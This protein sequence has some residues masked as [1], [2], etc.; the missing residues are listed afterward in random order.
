MSRTT[1]TIQLPTYSPGT[2]RELKVW[3]WGNPGA[4]PKAYFQAAL[5]ADEWPGL[6]A[7]HH[8]AGLLDQADADGLIQGE[9]IML[10][11]ANP[12][13]M[14]Q[15]V[16]DHMLGRFNFAGAHGNFNRDWPDLSDA[17]AERVDGKLGDDREA[18]ISLFRDALMTSVA[19]LPDTSETNAHSKALLGLSMDADYVFDLHCD[20]EAMLHLYSHTEHADTTMDLARYLGVPVVMLDKGTGSGPFDESHARPWQRVRDKLG[21]SADTL[22][23]TCYSTT[24]ELRGQADVSD[25]LGTQDATGLFGFLTH[26]GVIAGDAPKMPPALCDPIPLEAVDTL[27]APKAGIIAWKKKLGDQVEK[28]DLMA[29]IID[30]AEDDMTKARSPIVSR[31]NGILFAILVDRMVRAGDRIGK[32]AGPEP[33]EYRKGDN[34]LSN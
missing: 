27:E 24:V 14:A 12:I 23:A 19:E 25:E 6:M 3:R 7:S 21:L 26:C 8:L 34:L 1:E 5:H 20:S 10:P 22:P 33:L 16:D 15:V 2:H 28:G 31:Q 11:Y 17:V 30:I 13:G 9:I 4:R 29:E 18:N 32:I